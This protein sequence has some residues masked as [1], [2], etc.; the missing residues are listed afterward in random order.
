MKSEYTDIIFGEKSPLSIDNSD[1]RRIIIESGK[2]ASK[3]KGE[4]LFKAGDPVNHIVLV[5]KGQ[6]HVSR[7]DPNGRSVLVHPA[8]PGSWV[9]FVG[10]FYNNIWPYDLTTGSNCEI[11]YLKSTALEEAG[12]LAPEVFRKILE[13][14]AFYS[15]FFADHL[16]GF[17][18]KP[19]ETRVMEALISFSRRY[20]SNEI[21]M[22]QSN[23]AAFLGVT[24]EAI[25]QQLSQ[26]QKSG[27][28]KSG[29]GKIVILKKEEILEILPPQDFL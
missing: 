27:F 14:T 23:L 24:R 26:L 7:T 21:P 25:A 3:K 28:I 2:V 12:K 18:C 10:Y 17:V 11:F 15:C 9:G 4:I 16:M 20:Q 29:Y 6:L 5:L 1:F 13:V 22:T 8:I 19:L